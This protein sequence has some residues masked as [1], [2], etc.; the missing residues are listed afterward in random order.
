V[1][2]AQQEE[3][4]CQSPGKISEVKKGEA[5]NKSHLG[6]KD[7]EPGDWGGIEEQIE[8]ETSA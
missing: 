8:R 6:F 3:E 4:G 1:G 5:R 7:T 2:E